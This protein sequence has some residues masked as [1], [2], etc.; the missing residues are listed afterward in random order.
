MEKCDFLKKLFLIGNQNYSSKSELSIYGL[1][2]GLLD[3]ESN[4]IVPVPLAIIVFEK[5][6]ENHVKTPKMAPLWAQDDIRET[7]AEFDK[8]YPFSLCDK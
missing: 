4:G 6:L 1:L 7:Q 2:D 5:I 8:S 3:E